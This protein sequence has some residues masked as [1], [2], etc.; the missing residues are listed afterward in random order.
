MQLST[1]IKTNEKIDDIYQNYDAVFKDAL[2][3]YKDKS[4][5]FFGLDLPKIIEPL[6]TETK[7]IIVRTKI[8]DMTFK[9]EFNTGAHFEEEVELSYDDLCRF[10]I[11]NAELRRLYKMDFI[12]VIF[13]MRETENISIDGESLK[14]Y[15]K[16]I[17]CTKWDGD[18]ILSKL[19][20]NIENG[21]EINELE[22]IYLPLFGSKTKKPIELL[23]AGKDL[24]LKSKTDSIS[25]QKIM[26]LMLL[27]SNKFVEKAEL[28]SIWEEFKMV[29]ELKI[30]Q[31]AEEK[32]ME[33][34]MKKGMEK[35]MEKG[36]EQG[37]EKV[38]KMIENGYTL[39]DVKKIL[40]FK[41]AQMAQ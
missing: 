11:E 6:A 22:M 16:I 37:I 33:K 10:C 7:E 31:I 39:D 17:N 2:T 15:P 19:Q 34:G 20:Y 14:F 32:G 4:L 9:L 41:A 40:G 36:E 38:I 8:S 5:D 23:K 1:T 21:L 13:T 35:G 25:K 26:A 24:L 28:E 30:V 27:V 18:S 3:L 29:A 12:T